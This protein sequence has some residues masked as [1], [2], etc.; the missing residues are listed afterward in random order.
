MAATVAVQPGSL[1][2]APEEPLP[3]APPVKSETEI[4]KKRANVMLGQFLVQAGLIPLITLDSA[5]LLQD[6]V[7]N[8]VFDIIQAAE[9]LARAHNR[10]GSL[11]VSV[12]TAKPVPGARL[13][14]AP[15]LGQLLLKSGLIDGSALTAALH[16][17]EAARQGVMDK[18]EALD[19]FVKETF[20]KSRP[21]QKEGPE[22]ERT[23][24]LLTQA[25]LLSKQDVEVARKLQEKHGGEMMKIL[26]TAG[27]ID[28][29]TLE[30]AVKI[31][32][33]VLRKRL[34]PEQAIIVLDYC[35]RSRVTFED[36]IA[37]L[38]WQKP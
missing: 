24:A 18:T 28:P 12:F 23:L 9:A 38:G 7:K 30:A 20:G 4:L 1:P 16:F 29:K 15:P 17:Q 35:H 36:A 21:D 33:L 34:K 22:V 26:V 37:E 32:L 31:Q 2:V 14:N 25:N 5:L 11:E 27:K 13:P 8:G 10:G 6:I 19:A 3:S